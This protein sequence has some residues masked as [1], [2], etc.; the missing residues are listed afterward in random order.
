MACGALSANHF[1]CQIT[2]YA[3]LTMKKISSYKY[4]S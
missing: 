2:V 1:V 3:N 4:C